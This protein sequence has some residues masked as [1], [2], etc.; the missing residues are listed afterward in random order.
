ME[1]QAQALTQTALRPRHKAAYQSKYYKADQ[2]GD[3]P[4]HVTAVPAGG[5][6]NQEREQIERFA[7]TRGKRPLLAQCE[8]QGQRFLP[9]LDPVRPPRPRPCLFPSPRAKSPS[10]RAKI[11]RSSRQ[12]KPE[13]ITRALNRTCDWREWLGSPRGQLRQLLMRF[14]RQ[15]LRP[16]LL[17]GLSP[18][19]LQGLSPFHRVHHVHH[20]PWCHPLH[21]TG[22]LRFNTRQSRACQLKSDMAC[23]KLQKAQL[24]RIPV[25]NVL[26][27]FHAPSGKD[28]PASRLCPIWATGRTAG[29][30]RLL[31]AHSGRGRSEM[32]VS[33]TVH[34]VTGPDV[35]SIHLAPMLHVRAT[36][37]HHHIIIRPLASALPAA[38][39]I[40]MVTDRDRSMIRCLKAK[41]RLPNPTNGLGWSS[42]SG[43]RQPN[44]ALRTSSSSSSIPLMAAARG[45][46]P[47]RWPCPPLDG[48]GCMIAPVHAHGWYGGCTITS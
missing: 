45:A 9:P 21:P 18:F 19:L 27:S 41:I 15:E 12:I 32:H 26:V 16:F 3:M 33:S 23:R 30:H 44:P 31:M 24:G 40:F 25:K 28:G 17:R 5:E 46:G 39:K 10:L 6:K 48:F 7:H 47:L 11:L 42:R 37:C 36:I 38:A 35:Q 43:R 8:R 29:G 22:F 4:L 34:G 13:S 14:R 20:N 1:H 2:A